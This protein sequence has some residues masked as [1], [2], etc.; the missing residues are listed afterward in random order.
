MKL[1]LMCGGVGTKMWPA[2][3]MSRPKHF[4][5]LINGKSL[6]EINFQVLRKKYEVKDIFVQTTPQQVEL[7]RKIV[8]EILP[9]N[10]F[11]EPE[12]RNHGPATGFLAGK[13]MKISPD[14]VFMNIQTDVLRQP[15]EKFLQTIEEVEKLIQSEGKLV[16][17]GIRLD[18]VVRGIDF[19]VGG[20]VVKELE[21][22]KI[23]K[24]KRWVMRDEA[25]SYKA[26]I[27]GG[28]IFGHA[29]HYAWTPRLMLEAYKRLKP[30]WYAAIEKMMAAN[31]D[32]G[33]VKREYGLMEKGPVEEVTKVELANGYVF[34]CA[35]DWIDFGTWESVANYLVKNGLQKLDENSNFVWGDKKKYVATIGLN[36][37]VIVDT[38]DALLVMPKDQSGRVGEIVEKLKAEGRTELL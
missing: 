6:F 31:F 18:R 36:D 37:L 33:V 7:I 20:E 35:F 12:L 11:V 30:D 1:V 23:Y 29:N 10:I 26:E 25:D 13:L 19:I 34:E 2:S 28:I 3:R 5:P 16:T 4:L 27:E 15:E 17:G 32:E 38:G 22:V 21:G 8:P 24:T 9:E 14:E